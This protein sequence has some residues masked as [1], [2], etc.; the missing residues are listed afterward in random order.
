MKNIWRK[1][2]SDVMSISRNDKVQNT[3]A[4]DGIHVLTLKGG[5]SKGCRDQALCLDKGTES[6]KS[7]SRVGML[8]ATTA[9]PDV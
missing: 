7:Q 4:E 1:E 5:A 6:Y 3:L 8:A 2:L 9:S